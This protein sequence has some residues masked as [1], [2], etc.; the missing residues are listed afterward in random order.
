MLPTLKLLRAKRGI[1]QQCLADAIG[2]TQQSINQYENHKIEPDV[3]TLCML[4]DYFN[5]SVDYLIGHAYTQQTEGNANV[6]Y[7]NTEETDLIMKYRALPPWEGA[8]FRSC[9]SPNN[10]LLRTEA[11]VIKIQYRNVTI[12]N[13]VIRLD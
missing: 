10:R 2:L 11:L 7:L 13:I 12:R 1:S 8:V 6:I 3:R 5:T 9:F 4:A